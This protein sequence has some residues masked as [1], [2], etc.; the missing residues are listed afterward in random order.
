MTPSEKYNSRC[1]AKNRAKKIEEV[2]SFVHF[3]LLV[4]VLLAS[5]AGFAWGLSMIWDDAQEQQTLYCQMVKEKT[6]PDYKKI[7][8]KACINENE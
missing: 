5:C 1:K 6:W 7:Y 8:E 4:V 2:K 3:F